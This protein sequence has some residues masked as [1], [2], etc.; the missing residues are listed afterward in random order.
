[1][2]NKHEGNSVR[3]SVP[4][5]TPRGV[6]VGPLDFWHPCTLVSP[7]VGAG[8]ALSRIIAR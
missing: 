2:T 3:Y 6:I 1:M 5:T 4:V 8:C 7:D